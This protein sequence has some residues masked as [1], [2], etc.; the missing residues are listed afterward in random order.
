VSTESWRRRSLAFKMIEAGATDEQVVAKVHARAETVARW[1]TSVLSPPPRP[2]ASEGS[3]DRAPVRLSV[4]RTGFGA[5]LVLSRGTAV[6]A[7]LGVTRGGA[8][9]L[10]AA[11]SAHERS[12]SLLIPTI[13]ARVAG[14]A[15]PG[16]GASPAHPRER[17]T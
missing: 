8:W 11:G 3:Q 6:V 5:R 16:K 9:D 14:R 7:V 13:E 1:R 17:A 2:P 4:E 12:L 10:S 15:L